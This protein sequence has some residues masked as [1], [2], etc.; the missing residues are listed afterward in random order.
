MVLQLGVV[1]MRPDHLIHEIRRPGD[2]I[3]QRLRV[4]DVPEFLGTQPR[5]R[6]NRKELAALGWEGPFV[7][8]I[9]CM[10]TKTWRRYLRVVA[11]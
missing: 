9:N 11:S 6:N 1:S 3:E 7:L 2:V 4:S 5:D 10:P 8:R